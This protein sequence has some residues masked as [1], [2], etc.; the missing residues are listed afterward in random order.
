MRKNT[1]F[2]KRER[3][4]KFRVELL[5]G[6]N[7]VTCRSERSNSY[8]DGGS[9]G[10]SSSRNNSSSNSISSSSRMSNNCSTNRSV[11]ISWYQCW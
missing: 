11:I 5:C 9:R 6:K 2:V 10:S 8:S 4:A 1:L 7:I 3:V